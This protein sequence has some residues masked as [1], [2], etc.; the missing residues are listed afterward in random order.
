MYFQQMHHTTAYRYALL[1][2]AVSL[3]VR[4][5][6]A[7]LVGA[8]FDEAYYFTYAINP[9]LGYFD[10]PPMVALVA[11]VGPFLSGVASR[12]TIRLSSL[13][14]F[15]ITGLLIYRF[16]RTWYTTTTALTALA[17]FHG[18][19]M[20]FIGIGIAVIPDGPM[21]LFWMLTLNV[22][23]RIL[24]RSP[25]SGRAIWD[26]VLAGTTSGLILL[27][28]YHGVLLIGALG[29]YLLSYRRD[30][31]RTPG[32]YLYA[33][34]CFVVFLPVLFWNAQ[35]EWV[36][37]AFQGGRASGSSIRFDRF[38]QAVG[39]QIGYLTPMAFLPLVLAIW[40]TFRKGVFGSDENSRFAFFFGT[41]PYLFFLAVSFKQSILPHW[42]LA[43]CIAL[44]PPT[45]NMLV[46]SKRR[47]L[48]I[49][50]FVVSLILI[51]IL[52][53]ALVAQIRTGAIL[54][55]LFEIG[56]VSKRDVRK[57]A[58]LDMVGWDAIPQYLDRHSVSP[59]RT[60]LFSHKWYLGGEIALAAGPRFSTLCFNQQD[61][62]GFGVWN[63]RKDV[64]GKDGLC[65]YTN[66]YRTDPKISF[67]DYFAEITPADSIRISRGGNYAKTIYFVHCKKMI[68]EYPLPSYA[69]QVP[70]SGD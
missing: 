55:K 8:G 13:V 60:F 29:L 48:V 19:P 37:F 27:S 10:H 62:R 68:K 34:A 42:T 17:L 4:L 64:I 15:T 5:V 43:G 61:S 41:L 63:A 3:L 53:G 6:L 22:L 66:R 26:W 35:H 59:D 54:Q 58:T 40:H 7:G 32:P 70:E 44:I 30:L 1:I 51:A 25:S 11:G 14:L 9:A 28:K 16:V 39:G 18:I 24:D 50:T 23:R 49:R 2:S 57:D 47:R 65:I 33:A 38:L 56:W 20:F 46:S 12:F 69:R 31:L 52:Y 45:A 21:A 36:S 67:G